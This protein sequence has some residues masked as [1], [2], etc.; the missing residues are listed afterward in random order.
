MDC[1]ETI[2]QPITWYSGID[3]K[4]VSLRDAL[5]LEPLVPERDLEDLLT[6]LIPLANLMGQSVQDNK[7]SSVITE[8]EFQNRTREWLRQ[9]PPIGANLEEH[10]HSTGGETDLSF[11][12]IRIE[13]KCEGVKRLLPEDCKHYARQPASYAVGTNRRVAVLCVLDC[14]PKRD[15]PFP[16]EDGLYVYPVDTGT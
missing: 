1:S 9:Q 8:K 10:P 14:S 6:V 13:L 7:F 2:R 4:L 5:R 16:M 3:A 11:R 15:V 12:G